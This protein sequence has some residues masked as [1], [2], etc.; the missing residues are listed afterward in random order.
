MWLQVNP[1]VKGNKTRILANWA[2]LTNGSQRNLP[3]TITI[4]LNL[5][6]VTMVKEPTIKQS[7]SNGN[8]NM[9][10]FSH[11]NPGVDATFSSQNYTT[12]PVCAIYACIYIVANMLWWL[13][14]NG[15]GMNK[16]AAESYFHLTN[17]K[18]GGRF[19][20]LPPLGGCL[21]GLWLSPWPCTRQTLMCSIW[22]HSS[23]GFIGP[24]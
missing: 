16:R 6:F 1:T 22:P 9:E 21:V 7:Q 5:D 14:I 3:Y 24:F 12:V 10:S 19:Q 23:H 17:S 18:I 8:R 4:C 13:P 20:N 15:H 11:S 2:T